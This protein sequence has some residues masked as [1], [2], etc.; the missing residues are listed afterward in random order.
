M[1]KIFEGNQ[2]KDQRN[3]QPT[4]LQLIIQYTDETSR[5]FFFPTLI[6]DHPQNVGIVAVDQL[7]A[8][9]LYTYVYTNGKCMRKICRCRSML[10]YCKRNFVSPSLR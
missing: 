1:I 3:S 2:I 4:N 6:F 9:D 10:V 5:D 8:D 7:V